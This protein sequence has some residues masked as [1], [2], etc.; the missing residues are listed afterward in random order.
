MPN[1]T[2]TLTIHSKDGKQKHEFD[3]SSTYDA[4][5][6]YRFSPA[7][8]G[9]YHVGVGLGME[10]VGADDTVSIQVYKN[11]SAGYYGRVGNI[12]PI[13]ATVYMHTDAVFLTLFTSASLRPYRSELILNV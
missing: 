9:L 7:T 10:S 3:K 12:P 13:G 6:N 1:K 5:T 4:S 11:G 2:N 8:A